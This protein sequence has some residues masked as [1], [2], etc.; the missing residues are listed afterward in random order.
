MKLIL[1]FT[2]LLY[3]NIFCINYG[4]AQTSSS[5][6]TSTNK[7][8]INIPPLNAL[9]DSVLKHNAMLR[10]RKQHVE[11]KASTLKS[12]SIFWR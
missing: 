6:I 9:I 8:E 2:F 11:V 10:F 12:E 5:E 4:L 3:I 7:N 1:K